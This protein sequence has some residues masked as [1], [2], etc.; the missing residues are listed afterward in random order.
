[1]FLKKNKT[2]DDVRKV[3]LNLSPIPG[4]KQGKIKD[5]QAMLPYMTKESKEYYTKLI[6]DNI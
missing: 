4:L 5:L 2:I 3:L 6:N 1:M